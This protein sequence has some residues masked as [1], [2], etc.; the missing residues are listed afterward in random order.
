MTE[1]TAKI[2][3]IKR[4]APRCPGCI[5]QAL[6]LDGEGISYETIDITDTPS[7]I[8]EYNLTAVPVLLIDKP[9]GERIRIDGFRPAEEVKAL[10]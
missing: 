4:T 1:Q 8:D 9:N 5:M 3:L 2:T 10:L 6:Q 7:A